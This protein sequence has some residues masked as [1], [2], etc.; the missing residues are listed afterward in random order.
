MIIHSKLPKVGTTIFTIMSQL[1]VEHNAINLGQG[2]PDYTMSEE[3]IDLVN[4][5]MRNGYNQYPHTNGMPL[6]RQRLAEKVNKLYVCNVNGETDVTIT[7]G[8]TYAIYNSFTA[9]LEAGDEVILFDPAFDSYIPNI[10]VNGAKPVCINLRY[11]DYSIPWDE[12]RA[13]ITPKTKAIII[14]SPQ[15]PSGAVLSEDDINELRKTVEGTNIFIISDEVYEHLIYDGKKH[16]SILR[17]PDLF[18]RSFVCFSFGK[19]Y[20][21]TGWKMGYVIAPAALTAEF[22]RV[23]QFNCFCCSAPVQAALAEY[24]LNEEAYLSLGKFFQQ[25]RDYFQGLMAQTPFRALPSHGS[26]FQCY[27]FEGISNESD[28]DFA[29]RLVK[30]KGVAGIP[31]SNFY[32]DGTDNKVIR[33]CFA[34]KDETLR[35]AVERLAQ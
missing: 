4:N 24:L 13:K 23:H 31:L 25:K 6:L 33:F 9:I 15:N 19:T 14:N 32:Q 29:M 10:E 16:L 1:A 17:Y 12:V 18:E 11:P 5:A 21:C 35:L 34:K 27:S 8:G 7:V 22:R 28:K 20:H 3:L 26:Y 30:E 2:F